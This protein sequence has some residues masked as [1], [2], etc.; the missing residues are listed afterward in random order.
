MHGVDRRGLRRIAVVSCAG[1]LLGA[2]FLGMVHSLLLAL[3]LAGVLF[4]WDWSASSASR[5]FTSF[6]PR[7]EKAVVSLSGRRLRFSLPLFIA[8]CCVLPLFLDSYA[9]DVLVS[10]GLYMILALGLNIHVGLTGMLNLGF[11]A[12]YAVGAYSHALLSTLWGVSFWIDLAVGAVLAG[13]FG[14][15]L[16]LPTLRLRGDYLAIV[17]LGFGEMVR[18]VLNNW[19]SLTGGPNG[20]LGVGRPVLPGIDFT[21]PLS[22]YY[23]V[24]CGVLVMGFVAKR[25]ISSRIGRAWMAVRE[26]ELAAE[27]MGINTSAMKLL[28]FSLGAGY[29][30]I[31]GVIFAAKQTFV[32]PE[33]F[34]FLES[35]LVL[36]MVVLGGMGG[37]AGPLLGAGVLVLLPEILREFRL[38]RML[39][40]GAAMAALMIYRPQGLLGKRRA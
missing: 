24:L 3:S 35:V 22:F 15:L 39:I 12:F 11:I 19:D 8:F 5:R 29:A 34:T 33:S 2:P 13:A 32:S 14:W 10:M 4:L 27:A 17:T 20:I 30:G 31:A 37:L 36:C 25:L 7:I 21:G 6:A 18:I 1:G 16:C 28:A 26:D 9:Q 23:L 40:F 38:Y